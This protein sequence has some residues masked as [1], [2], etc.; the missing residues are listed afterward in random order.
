[1]LALAVQ[2]MTPVIVKI[3]EKPTKEI[4]MADILMGSAGI[5]ILFLVG[6]ALLGFGLGGLFILYRRWQDRRSAD[7]ASSDAFQLTRPPR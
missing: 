6:A 4:S 7:H 1:M 3:I 2:P 5:T